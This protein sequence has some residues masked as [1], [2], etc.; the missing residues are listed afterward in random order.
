MTAAIDIR[1][2]PPRSILFVPASRPELAAKAAAGDA[3]AVCIDL[4]DGVAE[5]TRPAARGNVA[6]MARTV[7]NAGRTVMVR[8]NAGAADMAGDVESLDAAVHALVVAKAAGADHL[9]RAAGL[10][11]GR[12]LD[13]ALVPMVESVAG[14]DAFA[15]LGRGDVP[16]L[17]AISVGIEDLAHDLEVGGDSRALE[18]AFYR[19]LECARRL[20]VPLLGF[21][22]SIGEF[23]DLEHY[24]RQVRVGVEMGAAGAFCIHPRQVAVLNRAFSPDD[25]DI[26][27]AREVVEALEGAEGDGAGAVA[28]RGRMV[29]RPVAARARRILERVRQARA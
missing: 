3:D 19:L 28:V 7:A 1:G 17:A 2:L 25:D 18:H 24:A 21:P 11:A 22:S 26:A 6:A 8:V 14:I 29:D 15:A 12:G 23:T 5:A 16:G 4:E 27:W 13:A 20:D 10:A 9:A